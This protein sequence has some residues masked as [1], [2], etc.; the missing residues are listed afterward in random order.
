MSAAND[1]QF[2]GTVMAV[3]GALVAIIILIIIAANVVAPKRGGLA[4]VEIDRISERLTPP[5]SVATD[6][7]QLQAASATTQP[8]A[9]SASEI[10]DRNCAACHANGVL[11]APVI[12]DQAAW[13]ARL[14]DKGLD[15]LV[16]HAIN[17]FNQMPARGGNSNLSD[18]DIRKTVEYM[19]G[20]SGI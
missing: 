1:Q 5:V 10:N 14:D 7:S 19:L 16:S 6:A 17:G 3:M 13:Q 11:N 15:T 8:A 18:D 12:G 4:Q 20:E 2:M 9:L